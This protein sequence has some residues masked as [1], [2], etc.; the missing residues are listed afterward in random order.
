MDEKWNYR[1]Y[2]WWRWRHKWI[3]CASLHSQ[4]KVNNKFK[5]KN[6]QKW[7]RIELYGSLTTKEL[8]KKHS[9]RP[10]ARQ[11]LV[12]RM[13]QHLHVN[14]QGGAT[15]EQDG[16]LNP[17]FQHGEIKPQNLWM[18][19]TCGGFGGRRNSQPQRRVHWRGPQGPRT[20]TK[21]PTQESILKGPNLLVGNSRG[22]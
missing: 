15:G 20:Y 6:N 8:K 7:Q 16:P 1:F 2:F 18:K 19:K 9:S 12:E 3:H 14:R 17:W 5:N 21:P 22:D 11:L 13:V 10:V 4:R